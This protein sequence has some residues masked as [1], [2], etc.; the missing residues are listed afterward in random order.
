MSALGSGSACGKLILL[1]EHVVVHGTPALALPLRSLT[2]EVEVFDEAAGPRLESPVAGVH[3]R[4]AR[5]LLDTALSRLGLPVLPPWRIVVRSTLPVG[6]GLGS[7][8]SFAVALLRALAAAAGR[9]LSREEQNAHAFELERIT[10]GQPSGIDNTTVSF[11]QPLWFRRGEPPRFLEAP[12]R[13]ESL[14]VL[15]SSGSPGSTREAVAHVR[16][17]AASRPSEFAELLERARAAIDT[18]L[19]AFEAGDTLTLGRSLDALQAVLGAL[20]VSTPTLDRLVAAARAAGA[21]GA[22]LTG[23]GG[24]GF[25]LALCRREQVDGIERALAASGAAQTLRVELG[26]R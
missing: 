11:E 18:G 20:G 4:Q 7:S 8:A 9:T 13:S 14:L 25:V 1:G 5:A 16:A 12:E 6:C 15:A 24:G 10:H 26:D 23:S 17:F 3:A 22:K 19:E 21:L 2:T